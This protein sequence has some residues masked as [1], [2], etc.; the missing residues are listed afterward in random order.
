MM[1]QLIIKNKY[2][3]V[4]QVDGKGWNVLHFAA[5]YDRV[6]IV[7]WLI[8]R[9]QQKTFILSYLMDINENY[10]LQIACKYK[11]YKVAKFLVT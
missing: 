8:E 1:T 10:P 9:H 2:S 11:N 5:R 7:H 3:D 6:D 4:D